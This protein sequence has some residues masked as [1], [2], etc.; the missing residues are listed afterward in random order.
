MEST[1]QDALAIVNTRRQLFRRSKKKKEIEYEEK[2]PF[3][4]YFKRHYILYLMV[5]PGIIYFIVFRYIPMIFNI[6]AL[7]TYSPY[8]GIAGSDWVGWMHFKNFFAG[9]D[10]AM[11]L[12]NTLAISFMNLII[13]FPMPIILALLLNEIKHNG[14]KKVVQ[15]CVYIPHFISLVVVYSLT[16]L[17]LNESNGIINQLIQAMTGHTVDFLSSK[18]WFRPILLLQTVWKETGYG[19]IIFLA[20]LAGVDVQLYEA[21][22]VDGAGR[23]KKMWHI[24]LP[25]IKSTIITMLIL[26]VGSILNTGY[27]QIFLLQNSLNRSVSEVFDTYVY[28]QGITQGSFSYATAVGLFK[29]I[30]GTIMVLTVN[31]IAKKSGEDGL[32]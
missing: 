28:K 18:A 8:K 19:T 24:T 11:L 10:F 22:E 29:G 14:Y 5:F 13:F 23:W 17:I 16:Y 1:K 2:I 12:T 3:L 20:A 27:E 4:K 30:V 9:K 32:Y 31:K 6:I 26:R 15:T 25:A 21:A 7:Q